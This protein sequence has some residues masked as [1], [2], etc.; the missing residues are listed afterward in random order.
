[1]RN[2][3]T[4]LKHFHHPVVGA[5]DLAY[6]SLDVRSTGDDVFVLNGYTAAPGTEADEKLKMLASWSA[7]AA[8][9]SEDHDSR[10]AGH[11]GAG[12]PSGI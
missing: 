9:R 5:I 1:V 4:G 10:I 3:N 7:S 11:R 6:D 2:H 8:R 12:E